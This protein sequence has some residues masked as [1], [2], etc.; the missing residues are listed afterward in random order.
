M[1][2]VKL[3]TEVGVEVGDQGLRS[4]SKFRVG[5]GV[6]GQ[7]WSFRFKVRVEFMCRFQGRGR[8]RRLGSRSGFRVGFEVC[9][10][11]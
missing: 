3:I 8:G 9:G 4:G 11:G 7:H 1:V 2:R 6:R 10:W 5:F